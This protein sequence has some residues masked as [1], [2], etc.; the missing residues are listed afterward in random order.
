[1]SLFY[2]FQQYINKNY[3]SFISAATKDDPAFNLQNIKNKEQ[4]K[5]LVLKLLNASL[6]IQDPRLADSLNDFLKIIELCLQRDIEKHPENAETKDVL[7]HIESQKKQ[8]EN[9]IN[10]KQ[11][12]LSSVQAILKWL[13][14][15]NKQ[16]FIADNL[17]E[18]YLEKDKDFFAKVAERNQ[19]VIS[20]IS[21]Q[22][23][24]MDWQR[25][26]VVLMNFVMTLF[27]IKHVP[28][29]NPD[30]EFKDMY[31]KT[32]GISVPVV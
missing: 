3:K 13:L 1:M 10:D 4:L 5:D 28:D 14:D 25:L 30:A 32:H 29:D 8:L 2:N 11:A 15:N 22:A 26:G 9:L 24:S 6:D 23:K 27:E 7:K 17:W 16:Q 21:S 20:L 12:L 19:S 31:K 18:A